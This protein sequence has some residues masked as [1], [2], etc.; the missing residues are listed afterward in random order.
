[1]ETLE[2]VWP[3]SNFQVPEFMCIPDEEDVT[4]NGPITMQKTSAGGDLFAF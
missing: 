3:E 4:I 1:M 2:T